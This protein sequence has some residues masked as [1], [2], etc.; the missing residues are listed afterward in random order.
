MIFSLVPHWHMWVASVHASCLCLSWTAQ[1]V[2]RRAIWEMEQYGGVSVWEQQ[3]MGVYGCYYVGAAVYGE[4]LHVRINMGGSSPQPACCH[5]ALNP[6]STLQMIK[7]VNSQCTEF[8]NL[9]IEMSQ[10]HYPQ[11]REFA[12][13]SFKMSHCIAIVRAKHM[14][15]WGRM[16][17]II[18]QWLSATGTPQKTVFTLT[19][20]KERS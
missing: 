6:P 2:W 4:L 20:S 8:A 5:A 14:S 15:T 11:C 13:L 3:Y 10:L 18:I 19:S 16:T 7:S 17:A 1:P 12:N 9:S